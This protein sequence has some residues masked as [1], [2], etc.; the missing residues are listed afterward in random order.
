MLRRLPVAFP[1]LLAVGTGPISSAF[2]G[3]SGPL[4]AA[5]IYYLVYVERYHLADYERLFLAGSLAVTVSV[6]GQAVTSATAVRGY[7]KR[8]GTEVPE[9]KKVDLE[10]RLP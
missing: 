6:L 8:A 10:G 2:M 5:A 7:A 3:W 1:A 4:G 9:G